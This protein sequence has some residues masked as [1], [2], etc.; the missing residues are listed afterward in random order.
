MYRKSL[1]AVQAKKYRVAIPLLEMVCYFERF[2]PGSQ[3]T[4]TADERLLSLYRL[5]LC[6]ERENHAYRACS[7]YARLLHQID[8]A[9]GGDYSALYQSLILHDGEEEGVLTPSWLLRRIASIH[10]QSG[11]Y[12]A[13]TCLLLRALF[14]HMS[15]ELIEGDDSQRDTYRDILQCGVALEKEWH[16]GQVERLMGTLAADPGL[17]PEGVAALTNHHNGAMELYESELFG[18]PGLLQAITAYPLLQIQIYCQDEALVDQTLLGANPDLPVPSVIVYHQLI[19]ERLDIL[20]ELGEAYANQGK[21][22]EPAMAKA[23]FLH[24][25][26]RSYFS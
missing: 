19:D 11:L 3:P 8:D 12:E 16:E 4:L 18:P 2:L 25:K 15:I 24:L 20:L 7:V 6:L 17:I 9:R 13:S 23:L 10:H 1:E 21:R 22:D 26:V 5:G 14:E